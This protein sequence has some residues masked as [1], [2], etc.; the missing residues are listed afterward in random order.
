MNLAGESPQP[1]DKS[2]QL[3]LGQ[4]P[5]N[6]LI[7]GLVSMGQEI[8]KVHDLSKLCHATCDTRE[9]A[10]QSSQR[11][12]DN[13]KLS[14]NCRLSAPIGKV[15]L[16][17]HGSCPCLNALAGHDRVQEDGA[18]VTPHQLR[19]SGWRPARATA[20]GGDCARRAA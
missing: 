8:P 14:L 10:T 15:R 6:S 13:L 7:N 12:P 18:R 19:T 16:T 3:V 2:R 9:L 11:F 20:G 5:N 4:A 17:T 1:D